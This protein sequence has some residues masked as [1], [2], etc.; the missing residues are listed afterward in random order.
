[1]ADPA[2]FKSV[3]VSLATY[4]ILRYLFLSNHYKTPLDF[5]EDML[6]QSKNSLE[7]INELALKSKRKPR[8][9]NQGYIDGK[10]QISFLI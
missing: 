9:L 3:S 2:K 8:R 6:E 7:R 1:M 4:K 10:K 5:T